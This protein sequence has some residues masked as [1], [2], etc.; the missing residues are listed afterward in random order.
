M[1]FQD[2]KYKLILLIFL[3]SLASS[4]IIS[5]APVSTICN[6]SEGC[7]IVLTS[8]YAKTFGIHMNY[9]GTAIFTLMSIMTFSHI[10]KPRK[11]KKS[12]IHLGIFIGTLIALYLLY[13][14]QFVL[15]AWCKYCLV[16][17]IGMLA[18]FVIINIPKKKEQ[19]EDIIEIRE[20]INTDSQKRG[21]K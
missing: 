20:E 16:I 7:N 2:F 11:H 19:N 21:D 3:L 9:L 8:L 10:R 5:L 17:D 1:T 18:A 15:H 4:L 6:P 13:L 14:Q 12:L